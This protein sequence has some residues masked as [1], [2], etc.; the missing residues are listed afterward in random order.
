[1]NTLTQLAEALADAQENLTYAAAKVDALKEAIRTH[2]DVNGPDK[3]AA[4]HATLVISTN[5]RFDPKKALP[6]IPAEI[7]PIVTRTE[8]V[9]DKDKLKALLPDVFEAAQNDGAYRVAIQ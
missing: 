4:G 7:L 5:R 6:L 2:P 3:Y 8:T 1:M 9:V